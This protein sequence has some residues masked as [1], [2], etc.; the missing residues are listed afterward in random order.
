MY[1]GT[2][3]MIVKERYDT[4]DRD[5]YGRPIYAYRETTVWGDLTPLA[6]EEYTEAAQQVVTRYRLHL[7]VGAPV[8][9]TDEVV[10]DGLTYGVKGDAEPHR[11]RGRLH[12]YEAIVER[13]TG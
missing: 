12:H 3:E 7:P 5:D 11:L 4:G 13:V 2:T 9:G 10:V 1:A 8:V 6:S